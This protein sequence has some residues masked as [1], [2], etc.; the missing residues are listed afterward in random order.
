MKGVIFG[1]TILDQDHAVTGFRPIVHIWYPLY[2]SA[3]F[4]KSN[5]Q[6]VLTGDK[7][8][9]K[10][11]ANAKISQNIH[12]VFPMLGS[13]LLDFIPFYANLCGTLTAAK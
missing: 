6:L 8:R 9:P 3:F 5:T 11:R 7:R 2:Q 1:L 12:W 13:G 4:A 10:K